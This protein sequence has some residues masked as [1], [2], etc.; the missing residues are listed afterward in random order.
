MKTMKRILMAFIVCL[1]LSGIT[2]FPLRTEM[3]FLVRY[4]NSFPNFISIWIKQVH[5]AISATPDLVLYGTDWLAF[6]HI[7]IALFFIPVYLDPIKYRINIIIGVLACILV[8]PLAFICGPIRGIPFFHQL[9]DCSFGLFGGI[10]LYIIN[11][12]I[13]KLEHEQ[14]S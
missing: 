2:A 13:K 14:F 3:D 9:I 8:F 4:H 6:A 7:I 11:N 12:K 10:L 5:A 1:L